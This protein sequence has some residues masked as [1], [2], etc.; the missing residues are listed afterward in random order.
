M[1]CAGC[2]GPFVRCSLCIFVRPGLLV[3]RVDYCSKVCYFGVFTLARGSFCVAEY[4]EL[5]SALLIYAGFLGAAW[6]FRPRKS[7][8]RQKIA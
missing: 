3:Q 2:V 1:F 6:V 7:R 4:E 5:T 8:L